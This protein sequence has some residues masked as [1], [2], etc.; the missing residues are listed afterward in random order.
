MSRKEKREKKQS[1]KTIRK[2]IVTF[3][4]VI[5]VCTVLKYAQN[6]IR[7]DITGRTNLIVNNSNITADLEKSIFIEN[8][9][10]YISK[11]DVSNFFDPYIYFDEKYNTIITGSENRISALEIGKTEMKDNGSTVR[12]S[13]P[14]IERDGTYYLPLSELDDIYNMGVEYIE[15]TDVVVVESLNRKSVMADSNKDNSVKYK[16]TA[17]SRTVDNIVRGEAV[18]LV[19]DSEED[20]WIR[21]RTKRGILGYV[22]ENT[23]TNKITMREDIKPSPKVEGKISLV[24]DYYSEYAY[25][26]ERTGHIKGINVVSPTMFTLVERRKR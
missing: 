19:N 23:L 21:V 10:V 5:C 17:I 25:A 12:I 18:T 6:F 8:G 4:F 11:E 9:A 15:E 3:L 1:N 13:A 2:L 24:W 22:K 14:A 26:P 16:P 20:G 7:N